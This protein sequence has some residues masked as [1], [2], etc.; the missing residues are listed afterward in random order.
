MASTLVGVTLFLLGPGVTLIFG[1]AA[2]ATAPS[3]TAASPDKLAAASAVAAANAMPAAVAAASTAGLPPPP[4]TDLNSSFCIFF[5]MFLCKFNTRFNQKEKAW[6]YHNIKPPS[7]AILQIN[8]ATNYGKTYARYKPCY[9][10][11]SFF[12]QLI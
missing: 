10:G 1:P 11:N 6:N 3:P 8:T 2:I 4:T 5:I 9:I 7:E 12:M